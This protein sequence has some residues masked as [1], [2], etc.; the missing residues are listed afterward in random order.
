MQENDDR[1]LALQLLMLHISDPKGL[2]KRLH[3]GLLLL[4]KQ[5]PGTNDKIDEL[6]KA[7]HLEKA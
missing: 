4:R 6:I 3:A 2:T 7:L 5:L 1:L